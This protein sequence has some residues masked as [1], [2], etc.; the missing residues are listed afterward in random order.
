MAR[1]TISEKLKLL[2][3]YLHK[4]IKHFYLRPS[5]DG[6]AGELSSSE[7]FVCNILGRKRKCTMT[8]LSTESSLALSSMTGVVDRLVD[9]NCVRRSRDEKDRRKVF[10]ELSNKGEE[11]Y[12]ALLEPE[13]EMIITMMDSLELAEQD[14]LLR[15]LGKATASLEM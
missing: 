3:E 8:E 7:L 6:V 13:M 14:A 10:V 1:R 12:Q 11:V 5:L 2:D 9:K 15:V 4:L